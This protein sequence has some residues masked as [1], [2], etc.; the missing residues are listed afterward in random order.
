MA[1]NG[2]ICRKKWIAS[3]FKIIPLEKMAKTITWL[4]GSAPSK[5]L[6]LFE[7]RPKDIGSQSPSLPITTFTITYSKM[8]IL[9]RL[10][11]KYN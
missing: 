9:C 3:V 10:Y 1:K 4:T 2:L 11:I 8:K 5:S 6:E 7:E